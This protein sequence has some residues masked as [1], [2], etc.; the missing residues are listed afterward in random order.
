MENKKLTILIPLYNAKDYIIETLESIHKNKYNNY[1]VIILD[2]F[3]TDGSKELVEQYI[4]DKSNFKYIKAKTKNSFSSNSRNE[5]LG[6]VTDDTNYILFMDH[7]DFIKND[8]ITRLMKIANNNDY[9]IIQFNHYIYDIKLKSF[10]EYCEKANNYGIYKPGDD[11]S[12]TWVWNKLIKWKLIKNNNIR[13]IDNSLSEDATYTIMLFNYVNSI[14]HTGT[15]EY[16]HRILPNSLGRTNKLKKL[17][18]SIYGY[19]KLLEYVNE[20]NLIHYRKYAL[21]VFNK[22]VKE[23]NNLCKT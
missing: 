11:I 10:R 12:L 3:S 7:D 23:L 14:F 15:Y 6:Y 2:D 17:P 16:Y 1:N 9:D 5:L 4:K 13:F 19:A 21:N 22:K 18:Y 20:H 8:T